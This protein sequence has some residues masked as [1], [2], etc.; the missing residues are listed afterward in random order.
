MCARRRPELWARLGA[1]AATD[2]ILARLAELLADEDS[3]VR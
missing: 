3:D 1:A 2:A